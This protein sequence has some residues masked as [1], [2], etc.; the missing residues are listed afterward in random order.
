[1]RCSTIVYTKSG[2]LNEGPEAEEQSLH[3]EVRPFKGNAPTKPGANVA[4][5]IPSEVSVECPTAIS[6][7]L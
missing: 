6:L 5:E 4:S 7:I 3:R 2:N 1:M